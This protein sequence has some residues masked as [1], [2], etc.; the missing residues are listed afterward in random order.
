MKR[1][2][3]LV[4]CLILVWSLT[5]SASAA[6]K[7]NIRLILDEDYLGGKYSGSTQNLKAHG[8]GTLTWEE[9]RYEGNSG[10]SERLLP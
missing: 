3:S 10:I 1:L 5:I 9:S 8:K 7:I 4:L 6:P 2:T